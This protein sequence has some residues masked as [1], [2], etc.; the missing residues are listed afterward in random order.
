MKSVTLTVSLKLIYTLVIG[1]FLT[2]SC[3]PNKTQDS[4]TEVN[5]P[6]DYIDTR[7]GTKPHNYSVTSSCYYVRQ[8]FRI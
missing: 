1:A 3:N 5:S 8:Y 6:I 2:V 4:L 7:I